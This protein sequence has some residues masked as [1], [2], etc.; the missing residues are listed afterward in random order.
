MRV[1]PGM[2]DNHAITFFEEGEPLVDGEPGDLVFV[3]R[4]V[5]HPH[6][7]RRGHDLF[8]NYTISLVDA[9]TGAFVFSGHCRCCCCEDHVSS[10]FASNCCW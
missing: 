1:E 8:I 2:S 9:L 6:W 10:S 7:E 5:P 3:V 4:T